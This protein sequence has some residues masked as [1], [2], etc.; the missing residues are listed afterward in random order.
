MKTKVSV[1]IIR[2]WYL[3]PIHLAHDDST[4]KENNQPRD[5]QV[6]TGTDT[7]GICSSLLRKKML[8]IVWWIPKGLIPQSLSCENTQN[9]T[10]TWNWSSPSIK[11]SG[12]IPLSRCLSFRKFSENLMWS[13]DTM[14][15]DFSQGGLC[16]LGMECFSQIYFCPLS[17]V[18]VLCQNVSN[19]IPQLRH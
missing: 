14:S 17:R 18:L 3:Q 6:R 19:T 8:P 4:R 13:L 7:H 16:S 5:S 2:T 15:K 11:G 9:Q 1:Y 10:S 12:V